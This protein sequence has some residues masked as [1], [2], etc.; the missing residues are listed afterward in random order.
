[1]GILKRERREMTSARKRA[2]IGIKEAGHCGVRKQQG[3]R[4]GRQNVIHI[5]AMCA[6]MLAHGK[7][8]E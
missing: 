8:P 7:I 6:N 3:N 1:M 4:A 2:L 5:R